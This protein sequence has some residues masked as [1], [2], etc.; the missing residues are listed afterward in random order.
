MSQEVKITALIKKV[1][2]KTLVSGDKSGR[3][4][5]ETL[6]PDDVEKLGE[7]SR[8]MEVAVSIKNKS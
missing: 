2:I 5:L 8:W 4:T 1:E 7:M 3:I 6:F